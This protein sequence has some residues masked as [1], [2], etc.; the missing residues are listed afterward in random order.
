MA[1]A[2]SDRFNLSHLVATGNYID[3]ASARI[4]GHREFFVLRPASAIDQNRD[5]RQIVAALDI[6][7]HH[8]GDF[9]RIFMAHLCV[10]EAGQITNRNGVADGEKI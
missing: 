10:T 1:A 5:R 3:S 2:R 4:V 6:F 8:H 9:A 7:I